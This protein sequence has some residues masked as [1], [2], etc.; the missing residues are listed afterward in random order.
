[1]HDQAFFVNG[2]EAGNVNFGSGADL[3]EKAARRKV[4]AFPNMAR[5]SSVPPDTMVLSTLK[6][7]AEAP[8]CSGNLQE[9]IDPPDDV[10]R[11]IPQLV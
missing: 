1:M 11:M 2:P 5:S 7:G 9:V 8:G 4:S 10:T 3:P 6:D